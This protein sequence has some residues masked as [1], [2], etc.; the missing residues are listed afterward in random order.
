MRP[1]IARAQYLHLTLLAPNQHPAVT[2]DK[3]RRTGLL[4]C[5]HEPRI[6]VI[7]GF[8]NIGRAVSGNPNRVKQCH[9]V[10]H[11]GELSAQ[12]RTGFLL[13]Q[14]RRQQPLAMR[15]PSRTA[16]RWYPKI[17]SRRVL[18]DVLFCEPTRL[19]RRRTQ[20]GMCSLQ[21]LAQ[22]VS[23]Q[24]VSQ[25]LAHDL[26]FTFAG[27]RTGQLQIKIGWSKRPR[28]QRYI[29]PNPPDPTPSHP[30]LT[31]GPML[32]Y[33]TIPVTPFQQNCSIVWCDASHRA[34]II[35]PGGDL[36]VLIA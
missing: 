17:P 30:T 1:S 33:Q 27:L 10:W 20:L 36:D 23:A 7:R 24:R 26:A 32:R 9:S 12:H 3:H 11:M 14:W 18:Q 2:R 5:T 4:R 29:H 6:V 8:V 31:P 21:G 22:A 28:Q 15:K 13:H 19:P 34:A 35:D 25:Q 16:T